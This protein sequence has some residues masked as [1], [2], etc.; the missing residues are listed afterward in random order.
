MTTEG[1][2]FLSLDVVDCISCS[3]CGAQWDQG[4]DPIP[5]EWLAELEG[6]GD[7]EKEE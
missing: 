4:G 2:A 1:T 7:G 6:E 5:T 3:K